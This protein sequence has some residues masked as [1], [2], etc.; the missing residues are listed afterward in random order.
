MAAAKKKAGGSRS[1]SQ[2]EQ[3]VRFLL[4][5]GRPLFVV[6]LAMVALAAGWYAVWQ[7]VGERVLASDS[8][9]ITPDKVHMTPPPAWVHADI[10]REVFRAASFDRPL[11]LHDDDLTQRIAEAFALHPWVAKVRRVQK[12]HPAAVEVV[13]DYRRPVCMVEVHG[14]LLPV[15]GQGV[16]LPKDDFSP[17]EAAEYP[18]LVGLKAPPVGAV[19]E[20]WS[21]ARVIGG[22]A[23]ADLL[24]EFWEEMNLAVIVPSE[25]SVPGVTQDLTFTLVTRL[26]TRI[27]W[28]RPPGVDV[29]GEIAAADKT[30]RLQEYFQHY[31]TLEGRGGPQELDVY[32]LRVGSRTETAPQ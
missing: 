11:S 31:G 12:R 17:V 3:F 15:D 16:L 22:A 7:R 25:P 1:P 20:P 2:L 6:G 9:R 29:P 4:G 26:G 32:Q 21:D 8:H 14:E 10:R 13:L 19:G 5:P 30:A 18:R 24:G 28:G 23:I 27:F